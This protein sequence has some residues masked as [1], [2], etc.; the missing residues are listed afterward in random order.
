MLSL[1]RSGAFFQAETSRASSNRALDDEHAFIVSLDKRDVLFPLPSSWSYHG[2][3][4]DELEDM[5]TVSIEGFV[6]SGPASMEPYFMPIYTDGCCL[7]NGRADSLA[8]VGVYFGHNDV[9]NFA[10][11][12][13]GPLQTNNRAELYAVVAALSKA[14]LTASCIIYT[15]SC[16]VIHCVSTV[17]TKLATLLSRKTKPI[18][19]LDL[20]LAVVD[21]LQRRK[22]AGAQTRIAFVKGHAKIPGNEAADALA[23]TLA[24]QQRLLNETEKLMSQIERS[25][26]QTSVDQTSKRPVQL[27]ESFHPL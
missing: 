6:G 16:Y 10:E 22:E 19:N 7:S 24:K 4:F 5:N 27:I 13:P 9:R 14:P 11:R 8:A 20:I 1:F 25:V 3:M 15:D 23:K 21:C 18:L 2:D 12:L 26:E 17:R